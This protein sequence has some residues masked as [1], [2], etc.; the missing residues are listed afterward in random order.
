MGQSS[1]HFKNAR[2]CEYL[3]GQKVLKSLGAGFGLCRWLIS[4][5]PKISLVPNGWVIQ[6]APEIAYA[7]P[8]GLFCRGT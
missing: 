8:Q 4:K 6:Q 7:V 2:L 3:L 5:R 1:H